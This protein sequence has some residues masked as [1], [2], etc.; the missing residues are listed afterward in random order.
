MHP[1]QP[2]FDFH[3]SAIL[4]LL[5]FLGTA[6]FLVAAGLS[7]LILLSRGSRF[8]ARRVAMV[9][10]GMGA[11]YL[12]ALAG[13]SLASRERVV[14]PGDA[15]HVCEI[16]CGLAYSVVGSRRLEAIGAARAIR[17]AWEIVTLRISLD[18]S[19]VSPDRDAAPIESSPRTA[20]L[21]AGGRLIAPSAEGSLALAAVEG[22]QTPLTRP[23]RPGEAYTTSLVF[24]VPAGTAD[25]VLRLT[26]SS[27][28]NRL[29]IGH[30]DS[31]L[32]ARTVFRLRDDQSNGGKS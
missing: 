14:E 20:R 6:A 28:L 18:P 10:M 16:D 1:I 3:G 27:L 31:L 23:L 11:A 29:L 26:G 17:G 19:T 5:A 21:V 32:H 15:E 8:A 13:F 24:D 22:A 12:A 7:L 25:P 9:A 4:S 30:E 2:L